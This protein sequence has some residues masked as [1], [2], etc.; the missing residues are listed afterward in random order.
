[1]TTVMSN[2]CTDHVALELV[3]LLERIMLPLLL[4]NLVGVSA[5][6]LE[7]CLRAAKRPLKGKSLLK[8]CSDC[9]WPPGKQPDDARRKDRCAQRRFQDVFRPRKP[10]K[11]KT[12]SGRVPLW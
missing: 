12:I 5:K 11:Q 2:L 9:A 3:L 1:M 4:G 8:T 10:D 7:M 6:L